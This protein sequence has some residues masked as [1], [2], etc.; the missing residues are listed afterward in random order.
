MVERAV[1]AGLRDRL[2]AIGR[3]KRRLAEGTFGRSVRSDAP[4]SPA[5]AS[6][7][8]RPP[9]SIG[10]RALYARSVGSWRAAGSPGGLL[11]WAA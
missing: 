3:A 6:A 4:P 10:A 2:E 7:P 11:P 8:I 5:T 9:S 1:A